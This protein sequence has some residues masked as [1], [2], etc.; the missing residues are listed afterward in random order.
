MIRLHHRE[1]TGDDMLS[2]IIEHPV[3]DFFTL[4]HIW[5]NDLIDSKK[6]GSASDPIARNTVSDLNFLIEI[7]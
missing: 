4:C 7:P 6:A 3:V 5:M 2:L 1:C